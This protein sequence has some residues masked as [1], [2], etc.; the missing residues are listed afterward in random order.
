ML[1]SHTHTHT[2]IGTLLE[3]LLKAYDSVYGFPL[4]F[5]ECDDPLMLSPSMDNPILYALRNT[6]CV[7]VCVCVCK[8]VCVCVDGACIEQIERICTYIH[9][10]IHSISQT[11]RVE[12]E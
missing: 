12:A 7:C 10:Y 8:C 1:T 5:S 11:A 3:P 6:K 2:H 4:A 9:L